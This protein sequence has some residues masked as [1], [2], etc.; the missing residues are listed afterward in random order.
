MIHSIEVGKSSFTE[1]KIKELACFLFGF[2]LFAPLEVVQDGFF[3]SYLQ[4][5]LLFLFSRCNKY[6]LIIF[7]FFSVCVVISVLNSDSM[8]PSSLINPLLC[9]LVFTINFKNSQAAKLVLSGFVFSAIVHSVFLFLAASSSNNLSIA[10]LMYNRVWGGDYLPYFGNGLG[11][12]FSAALIWSF[13]KKSWLAFGIIIVGAVLT[14]SRTPLLVCL[15][16]MFS[17]LIS[18]RTGR[19]FALFL[20]MIFLFLFIPSELD[21]SEY[22]SRLF[23]VN[24]RLSVYFYSLVSIREYPLFGIGSDYLE[25]YLHAHNSFLQ[26]ALK[27]GLI[28][29]MFWFF[30]I[31]I[32][33]LS[34]VSKIYFIEFVLFVII[35]GSTQIGLHNP[36]IVVFMVMFVAAFDDKNIDNKVFV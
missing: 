24:D 5:L 4:I 6:T 19:I 21:I 30:I 26:V 31:F 9:M 35:V 27:H 20:V 34:R 18:N 10:S 7:V 3:V 8:R 15:I 13:Y 14:T 32:V 12:T 22:E 16:L 17:Q 23:M 1:I 28:A 25:Y 29:F 11:L 2:I 36:N 33:F